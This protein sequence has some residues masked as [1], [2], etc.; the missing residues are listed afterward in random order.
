MFLVILLLFTSGSGHPLET[1]ARDQHD[2]VGDVPPAPVIGDERVHFEY[3]NSTLFGSNQ[4]QANTNG[5]GGDV[6]FPSESTDNLSTKY[7]SS[8]PS[9]GFPEDDQ[10][11]PL[12]RAVTASFETLTSPWSTAT[13]GTTRKSIV[14]FPLS[15]NQTG[16]SDEAEIE[17]YKTTTLEP[18]VE[19]FMPSKP[20]REPDS[21]LIPSI[22]A[23]GKPLC[24][25]N[26]SDTFCESVPEYPK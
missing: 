19:L 18:S 1:I 6:A 5:T 11:T 13:I 12:N 24:L 22:D 8:E 15:S 2:R 9:I 25:S 3:A 7:S 17:T 20:L 4:Q 10:T 23:T 26:P 16:D 21:I 14:T